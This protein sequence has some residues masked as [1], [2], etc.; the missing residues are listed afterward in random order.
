MSSRARLWL[1][2]LLL[3]GGFALRAHQP[4]ALAGFVD[5]LSHIERSEVIYTI[6]TNPTEYSHGKLLYYYWLGLFG[7]DRTA[8]LEMMRLATAL[9]SLLT[10]AAVAASARALFGPGAALAAALVY[11]L[12]PF[13]VFFERMAL[14]DPLATALATLTAWHSVLLARAPSLR[15][16][17]VTALLANGAILAKL[18]AAPVLALPVLAAIGF[19][20]VPEP[21]WRRASVMIYIRALWR[22]YWPVWRLIALVFAIAWAIFGVGALIS[23]LQGGRPIVFNTYLTDPSAWPDDLLARLSGLWERARYLLSP[24]L[25][26]G[27]IL[28]IGLA[29]ARRTRAALY[30]LAWLELLWAPSVFLASSLQ[31]RYLLAGIPALAVLIGGGIGA[32]GRVRALR[33]RPWL[34][35]AARAATAIA[36]AIWAIGFALPFDWRASTDPAALTVP[37]RDRYDYYWG[38]FNGWGTREALRYLSEHGERVR[39][40]VPAVGVLQLCSISTLYATSEID[41]RCHDTYELGEA[42]TFAPARWRFLRDALADAGWVYVVTEFSEAVPLDDPPVLPGLRWAREAVFPKPHG[43]RVVAVWRVTRSE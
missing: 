42:I 11:A 25:A 39:G 36:L 23:L 43:E 12:A 20:D 24:G 31:T 19:G 21:D 10:L 40:R 4:G 16:G 9:L 28:L 1:L 34:R 27:A 13:A 7:T 8:A 38:S 37:G 29:L 30:T 32:I 17:L 18:T 14:A 22:R 35:M 6:G 3:F 5:E 15:R 41:W 26:I 33:R 2:T